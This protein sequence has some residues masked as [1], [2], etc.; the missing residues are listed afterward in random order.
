MKKRLFALS[1][2]SLDFL[3]FVI[4]LA[5]FTYAAFPLFEKSYISIPIYVHI[6]SSVDSLST[7]VAIMVS[8]PY[9]S[10]EDLLNKYGLQA[11]QD[12]YKQPYI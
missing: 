9:L 2:R 11:Y 10:V 5:L 4:T 6:H 7:P 12:I 1:S 8:E 3:L